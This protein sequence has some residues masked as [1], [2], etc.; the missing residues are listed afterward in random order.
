MNKVVLYTNEDIDTSCM[1]LNQLV[2]DVPDAVNKFVKDGL[3]LLAMGIEITYPALLAIANK[4]YEDLVYNTVTNEL[5]QIDVKPDAISKYIEQM[6]SCRE[7]ICACD[8][9]G[10]ADKMIASRYFEGR[11]ERKLTDMNAIVDVPLNE[12]DDREVRLERHLYD[13]V[14]N[15]YRSP[16]N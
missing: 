9:S 1:C 2:N 11:S 12:I 5:M 10:N 14:C 16:E 6:D 8:R 3:F 13:R 4:S 7:L 15:I